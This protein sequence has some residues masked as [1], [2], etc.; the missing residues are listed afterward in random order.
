MGDE[1]SLWAAC[2]LC[3][4]LAVNKVDRHQRN[5]VC[6]C[7][8]ILNFFFLLFAKIFIKDSV[9]NYISLVLEI[10]AIQ[11]QHSCCL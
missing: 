11:N 9:I 3:V 4:A 5:T 2:C 7:I 10:E 6:A 8:W 1:V